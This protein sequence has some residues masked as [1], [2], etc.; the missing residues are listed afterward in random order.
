[1]GVLGVILLIAS[2]LCLIPAIIWMTIEVIKSGLL[3]ALVYF[4]VPFGGIIW[5]VKHWERGARP[6][7]L[8]VLGAVLLV[9]AMLMTDGLAAGEPPETVRSE[10]LKQSETLVTEEDSSTAGADTERPEEE[11]DLTDNSENLLAQ[12]DTSAPQTSPSPAA[13][14]TPTIEERLAQTNANLDAAAGMLNAGK[15]GA[16]ATPPPAVPDLPVEPLWNQYFTAVSQ[17]QADRPEGVRQF[18]SLLFSE[19]AQWLRQNM[20]HL[21]ELVA[22]GLAKSSP[23]QARLAVLKALLRNMPV[24]PPSQPP[25]VTHRQGLAVA[26]IITDSPSG[27]QTFTTVLMQQN[28]RWVLVQPFFARTFIWTPQ[29]AAYKRARNLPLSADEQMYA[30]SGTLP[31]QQQVQTI[32]TAVGYRP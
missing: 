30:T 29:L 12:A 26:R 32:Y 21:A 1:M 27:P 17:I 18:E 2:L 11:S 6:F 4:F 28:G 8:S 22:P 5:L 3:W 23:D 31:F 15:T 19:D 10:S 16:S 14:A 20:G 24:A 7:A 9:P 25:V 13:S